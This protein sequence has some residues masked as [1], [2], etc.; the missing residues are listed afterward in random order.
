MRAFAV[1]MALGSFCLPAM[2]QDVGV[3]ALPRPSDYPVHQGIRNATIGAAIVP[4]DRVGKMFSSDI[5]KKY[6]VV[7]VAVYPA[8]GASFDVEPFDFRLRVG[9]RTSHTE[10]PAAGAVWAG[11][12]NPPPSRA[13][14]ITTETGVYVGRETDPYGR[15]IHTVGTYTGV[16]VTNANPGPPPPPPNSGPD[17]YLIDQRVRAKALGGGLT[18]TPVAG[19]LYFPQSGKRR[20]SDVVELQFSN[21]DGSVGMPFPK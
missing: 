7:E 12:P 17:P 14:Q 1:I 4:A 20:K 8:N 5:A 13:P 18:Q 21:N 19:Y 6:I 9:E 2:A 11:N 16:S 10:I 3:P 15:P